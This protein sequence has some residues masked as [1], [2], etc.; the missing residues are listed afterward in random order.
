M[1]GILEDQNQLR[2]R[3]RPIARLGRTRQ[4]PAISF[5]VFLILALVCLTDGKRD[6]SR[7]APPGHGNGLSQ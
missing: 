7:P 3:I 4:W 5:L 6:A 2:R 1:V